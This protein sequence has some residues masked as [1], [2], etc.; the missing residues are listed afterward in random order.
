MKNWKLIFTCIAACTLIFVGCSKDDDDGD[1]TVPVTSV[2]ITE[3]ATYSLAVDGT[4]TFRATVAPDNATDKT[5][6]WSSSPATTLSID[7]QTG[8]ARGLAAGTA[9][10][11]ATAGGRTATCTVTVAP[12]VVAVT[13]ITLPADPVQLQL[14]GEATTHQFVPTIAPENATNKTVNYVSSY[15]DVATVNAE[16]LITAVAGGETVITATTADGEFTATVNVY[17][18]VQLPA[19]WSYY[20]LVGRPPQS[21]FYMHY[22]DPTYHWSNQVRPLQFYAEFTGATC[23]KAEIVM[24]FGTEEAAQAFCAN[25]QDL[26]NS[27]A[28]D[29]DAEFVMINI[30]AFSGNVFS[31]KTQS[32]ITALDIPAEVNKVI[33]QLYKL[34]AGWAEDGNTLTHTETIEENGVTATYL[35]TA[36]MNPSTGRC[37][38]ATIKISSNQQGIVSLV[39]ETINM[40]T[41]GFMKQVMTGDNTSVTFDVG[42]LRDNDFTGKTKSALMAM[43][44]NPREIITYY[45]NTSA[46][47]NTL[48]NTAAWENRLSL[49]E[50]GY[51]NTVRMKMEYPQKFLTYHG[52]RDAY[53]LCYFGLD[54]K[55]NRAYAIWDFGQNGP[56]ACNSFM[57]DYV[58][59]TYWQYATTDVG[60]GQGELFQIVWHDVPNND[61][62]GWTRQELFPRTNV[63]MLYT[64][65][66]SYVEKALD[67]NRANSDAGL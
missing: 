29:A 2:T 34:P 1:K 21:T 18:G 44:K 5:V 12:N 37:T 64:R 31:G 14:G 32:Q 65:I 10:V 33:D 28:I 49:D 47:V 43:A 50:G 60:G 13:G 36:T 51:I 19:K 61:F 53:V 54:G 55:C 6:S 25:L 20:I 7:A 30:S 4:H 23:T 9:T 48:F 24:D 41:K 62:V 66:K 67:M 17:V 38:D 11:T 57:E 52:L 39:K 16:G 59:S 15:P 26:P 40:E 58:K 63:P 27:Q 46:T 45:M 35:F 42:A 22:N 56:M 8:A 3:G